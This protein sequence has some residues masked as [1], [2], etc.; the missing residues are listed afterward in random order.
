MPNIGEFG[1]RP[2]QEADRIAGDPD[3]GRIVCFC[4]RVTR[5][6]S[7]RRS[8]A[9]FRPPTRTGYAAGREH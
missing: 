1:S 5:G 4:E 8:A 2:Y 3:Y 9:R 7:T 6:R